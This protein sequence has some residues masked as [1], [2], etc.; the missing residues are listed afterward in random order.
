MSMANQR[1][2]SDS[3]EVRRYYV[4]GNDNV[5]DAMQCFGNK[6]RQAAQ[7]DFL[8]FVVWR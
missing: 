1:R 6:S 5:D 7:K 2:C 4:L 3:S 8:L